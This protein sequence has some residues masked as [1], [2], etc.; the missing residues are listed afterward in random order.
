MSNIRS[1]SAASARAPR[2]RAS[3][4]APADAGFLRRLRSWAILPVTAVAF[5]FF[6]MA[7]ASA[8]S[9]GTGTNNGYYYS[10]WTDGGGSVS[11]NLGSGGNYSTSWSNVGNFVAGKGWATGGR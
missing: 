6:G 3:W 2:R 1:S 9:P 4:R 5:L 10:F 8:V 11:M 7:N